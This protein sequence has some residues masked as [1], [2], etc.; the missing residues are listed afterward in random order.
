ME[1]VNEIPC[2]V[3]PA[4]ENPLEVDPSSLFATVGEVK[5]AATHAVT[6]TSEEAATNERLQFPPVA[7]GGASREF[8]VSR[9]LG[10][11]RQRQSSTVSADEQMGQ[12]DICATKSNDQVTIIATMDENIQEDIYDEPSVEDTDEPQNT[13][14]SQHPSRAEELPNIEASPSVTSM[15]SYASGRHHA[16]RHQQSLEIPWSGSRGEP[17]EDS[18][19]THSWR[20]TS[21]V[22]SRRQSTEDSIDSEDEWYCYELRK[23][24]ELERQQ[25]T[26]PMQEDKTECF[27]PDEDVKEQ[28]SFVLQELKLKAKARE[29]VLSKDDYNRHVRTGASRSTMRW[30]DVQDDA[31]VKQI[32]LH[33]TVDE[34]AQQMP[35]TEESRKM[36]GMRV[37]EDDESSSG[38]TSGPDS[39]HQSMDEMEVDEEEAAIEAELARSLRS[40]SA[41]TLRHGEKPLQGS[42]SLSREGSVSVP[43]SE[44]SVS[45]PVSDGWDSE[46]TAT[47][48]E[49][50]VSVPAS[51]V[52]EEE[53]EGEGEAGSDRREGT[54][55]STPS[56]PTFK[57]DTDSSITVKDDVTTKDSGQLGSKWK[58]LKALKERKAEEKIQEAATASAAAEAK[59]NSTT[60]GIKSVG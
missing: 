9:A 28:M 30:E 48:R 51:D 22:S 41:S 4:E 50:S 1:Q 37:R 38:E 20:S 45:I 34:Q 35:V 55:S 5:R 58:L 10:K 12:E 25:D 3:V 16:T 27:E 42:D 13:N 19:S 26:E 33:P 29:G 14:T 36:S 15:R 6:T 32:D 43:P 31:G 59:A 40:S 60:V 21:R 56:V 52:W 44:V 8:A 18:R 53:A 39:P 24:E 49:G 7:L 57:I 47:V 2:D 46:E 11:Y 54:E 23:L 17:D